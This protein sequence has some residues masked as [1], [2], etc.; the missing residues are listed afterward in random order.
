MKI[1]DIRTAEIKGHGYSTYVR[2]YTDEGLI[3]NGEC[4][5]GGEGCPAMV[6]ALK[7][8]IIGEDPL[9]VDML[10]EKMRRA[11]LF[12]GAM[13]GRDRHRD[14]R[15]RDRALGS[16][17]QGAR[18]AGLPAARRQVPRHASASTATATP[19][20]TSRRRRTRE[21]AREV[22][23]LGFDALKFDVDETEAGFRN[24]RWNWHAS[25][26][27]DRLDGR[28]GGGGAG[29]GRAEDRPGDRHARPLRHRQRDR[30]RAGDGAVPTCSGWRSRCRRKTS[31][32]C[33]R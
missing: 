32:R 17:R 27:R 3:G 20:A 21:R 24:D 23:A 1:T 8:Y 19:G 4:I 31:P 10:F 30:G 7:Q 33:A 14:D 11:R 16:G 28:A 22:V 2:V 6:H 13:A 15:D 18:R 29:G 5:H 25:D 12:D 9:N 26:R